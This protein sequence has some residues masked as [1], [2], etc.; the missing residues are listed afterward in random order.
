MAKKPRRRAPPTSTQPPDLGVAELRSGCAPDSLGFRTTDDLPRL[1]EVIGQPRAFRAVKLGTEVAGLGYN[2]FVLGLPGSGK[3]T[4]VREFLERKAA[5]KPA[6][7]DWCY[8]NNFAN[9]HE[10]L[11]LRLPA[12]RGV[13]LRKDMETLVERSREALNRAFESK[14]YL[15][16][17]S[18]LSEEQQ[19]YAEKEMGKLSQLAGKYSFLLAR[20]PFGFMLVPAA[21]GKP[22]KPEQLAKLSQ[23]QRTKLEKIEAKLQEALKV[24][25]AAVREREKR[26]LDQ[27]AELDKRTALY[28]IDH[29]IER[30]K[31]GYKG[32][33]AV[34]RFLDEVRED[35]VANAASFRQ[36]GE[37][38][39][40]SSGPDDD[41]WRK[42]YSVN[43]IV[44]NSER[45][46][47]PVVVE[48]HPSFHN[49]LGRLEHEVVMGATRTDFT[50]IFPGAL[51]RANGGYLILPARDLLLSPYAWEG[52]KRSLREE[53]IR[54]LSLGAYAGLMSTVSLDPEPIPLDVKIV[55]IGTPMLYYLLRAYDEDFEKLFK[56]KAEFA[57]DMPR[58]P[59]TEKEYALFVK[60]VV[61]DNKLA[62]FNAAAVARV[63]EFG[64]RLAGD[65]RKLSTRFG[66]IA[67]LIRESAYWA[68]HRR[69][70][71]VDAR[72]VSRA[73]E[74]QIFRSNLL[75]ERL[76]EMIGDGT[77]MIDVRGKV[78]GQ[79]NALSVLSLGDYEF[80]RPTRVTAAVHPGR[81]GVINVEREAELSGPIHTKGVLILTGLLGARYGRQ[82]PLSLSASLTF[83]QSYA[84]VEGDSASAAEFVALLSALADVP[85]RQDRALTGSINQRGEIQPVGGINEKIEG[86][87][88]ICKLKGLSGR[89][90]VL[91]P[92]GNVPHLMLKDDI[93]RAVAH[94][95][96]HIWPVRAIDEV[97]A[98]LTGLEAGKA[99]RKGEYPPGSFNARV[100]ERLKTFS[101]L[102]RPPSEEESV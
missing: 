66:K 29:L 87:F 19:A 43:V 60:A 32:L 11:A 4:L 27:V 96:F 23:E 82:G 12:G 25:L 26:M 49:L 62:P 58:T 20:T 31:A 81:G 86:F 35:I 102:V 72:S 21:E 46:C 84:Q 92:A 1:Q 97:I 51:H 73:I 91:I 83:E 75:E 16:E 56:V 63:V 42:R 3:T 77:I 34:L 101:E 17:R 76:Q 61:E 24:S 5:D 90:G 68:K 10:P 30:M 18:R 59:E 99:N 71:I 64:S 38:G 88:A 98:I 89:Q 78:V 54:I 22:L 47:A 70:R 74:E 65:Q 41:A 94:E 67:D 33:D 36:Q 80:G 15:Q 39:D 53:T 44:D 7:D 57:T 37:Q 28:A 8:V 69:K 95:R 2:I 40:A 48:N 6:P 93:L 85:L 14:E 100:A 13:G 55:L 52:L 79:V 9:P 50:R 45:S